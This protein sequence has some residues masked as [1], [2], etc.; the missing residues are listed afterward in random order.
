VDGV[1]TE[2]VV[3]GVCCRGGVEFCLNVS[4]V[5]SLLDPEW[6]M[7]RIDGYSLSA[8]PMVT[9]PVGRAA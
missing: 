6:N 1:T 2:D 3:G 7:V 9:K 5:R 4:L 8:W